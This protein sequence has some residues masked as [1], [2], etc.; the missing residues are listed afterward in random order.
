MIKVYFDWNVI[1]QMKNGSHSGLEDIVLNNK[2][3]F[4]PFSTSHITDIFSSFNG[5]EDQTKLIHS[6]LDYISLMTHDL[7]LYDNGKEIVLEYYS[8]RQLFQQKVQEQD[9]FNDI[10]IDGLLS[11]LKTTTFDKDVIHKIFDLLKSIPIDEGFLGAFSNPKT[12]EQMEKLLP[13]LKENPTMEGFFES[14]NKM[15]SDLN[16]GTGYSDLRKLIQSGLGINRD[17]VFAS[18]HPFKEINK[19]YEKFGV[20]NFMHKS[21]YGPA[22]FNAI[23]DQYLFL[24]THGYQEDKVKVGKG[25]K[26]TFR[27]TTDDAFHAAF[28]SCC[29][30]YVIND[31]RSYNKTKQAYQKLN[32]NTVVLNPKEF[33]EYHDRYL[34]LLNDDLNFQIPNLL[35]NGEFAEYS[36]ETGTLRIFQFP[37]FIFNFFNKLMIHIPK[38]GGEPTMLLGQ[39]PPTNSRH[40]YLMEIEQLVSNISAALGTD[41]AEMGN[42]TEKELLETEWIGRRWKLGEM[43]LKLVRVNGHFQLYLE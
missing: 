22:W 41:I 15:N 3:L 17:R 31:N 30:F 38:D 1:S 6:D 34:E 43:E 2:S 40:T 5:L 12:A 36:V 8:P 37:Y 13:G 11:T 10:S 9:L 20:E 33:I 14:F 18:E 39:N 23:V 24:D 26:E 7:C 29:N 28:A 42:V 16:E 27:N 4:I 32:I 21:Q 25:R 35:Q 19:G